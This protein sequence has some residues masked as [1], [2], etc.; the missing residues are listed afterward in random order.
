MQ[1]GIITSDINVILKKWE[2]DY[3]KLFGNSVEI[4]D[5]SDNFV[6]IVQETLNQWDSEYQNL[7]VNM[8][9]SHSVDSNDILNGNI[10]LEEVNMAIKAAKNGKA[11]GIDNIPNEILKCKAIYIVLQKTL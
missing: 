7:L 2:K 4:D 1:D 8:N 5:S 6:K 3:K 10:T 11:V 9:V